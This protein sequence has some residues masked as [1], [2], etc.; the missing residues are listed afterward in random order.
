M[1]F[2]A[3]VALQGGRIGVG[4][5]NVAG[6]HGDELLMRG[7]IIILRQ[8]PGAHQLFGQNPDEIQQVLGLAVADVIERVGRNGK[9]IRAVFRSGGLR[10]TRST[11]STISSMYVKSRLQFP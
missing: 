5:G 2:E 11:P 6:L 3:E 9:A 8:N 10:M 7:K 1:G 4:G